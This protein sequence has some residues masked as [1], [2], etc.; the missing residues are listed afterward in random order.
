MLTVLAGVA[1][2]ERELIRERAAQG[3][4]EAKKRGVKFGRPRLLTDEVVAEIKKLRSDGIGVGEIMRRVNLKRA[5]VF[6]ALAMG[7]AN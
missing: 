3:I 1:E 6:K 5:T 7:R 2:L 4:K